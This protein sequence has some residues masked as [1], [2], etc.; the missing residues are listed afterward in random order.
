M[1]LV[2]LEKAG[3]IQY[4]VTQNIDG[5]HLRSGFPRRKMAE[6]HGN[7]YLD[8][9]SVCKR[10]FVR[11][12]AVSTVGQK[13]LGVGCPG[14]RDTGRQCRGRLHD[15][16]LDWEHDL[17]H[18]D[19][20]L[21]EKHSIGSD[22]S[23]CLGT[24]LQIIPSGVLPTLAKQSDG[25][26][27]IC[28]LQPTKHDK[29][30]DIIV[31]GYVDDVMQE[32]LSLL[33]IPCAEYSMEQDP[34]LITRALKSKLTK[35]AESE[36]IEW[37]IPDTWFDDKDLIEKVRRKK[38]IINMKNTG[39][40]CARTPKVDRKKR[41][42]PIKA[43]VKEKTEESSS[44]DETLSARNQRYRKRS[45][46]T[47][48]V[49]P[50]K[51]KRRSRSKVNV[52]EDDSQISEKLD[53]KTEHVETDTKSNY[54][55]PEINE[56]SPSLKSVSNLDVV[57]CHGSHVG[58]KRRLDVEEES[59]VQEEGTNPL[60]KIDSKSL[61]HNNGEVSSPGAEVIDG[62]LGN[63]TVASSSPLR[64]VSTKENCVKRQKVEHCE[65]RDSA[66]TNAED[67][68]LNA[69]TI[70][71][72]CKQIM[73]IPI[74]AEGSS[75]TENI[76]LNPVRSNDLQ[77]INP[78]KIEIAPDS[79]LT[80]AEALVMSAKMEVVGKPTEMIAL[81]DQPKNDG[82]EKPK[83]DE[84]ISEVTKT[85]A[86]DESLKTEITTK[87]TKSETVDSEKSALSSKMTKTE[88]VGNSKKTG[89]ITKVAE[90]DAGSKSAKS[91]IASE[92]TNEGA[93]VYSAKTGVTNERTK[94][95]T[96]GEPAKT[97]AV[98]E[99]AETE[100]LS[101]MRK[102]EA[103]TGEPAK[104]GDINDIANTDAGPVSLKAEVTS[105]VTNTLHKIS[106]PDAV[107]ESLKT[108]AVSATPKT[109]AVSATPRTDAVSATPKTDAVSGTPK[110]DAA[111]GTPIR[112][113][114][115][116]ELQRL[117]QLVVLPRLMQLVELLKLKLLTFANLMKLVVFLKQMKTSKQSKLMEI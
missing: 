41:R 51:R 65:L 25:K 55:S 27:V 85:E 74:H 15:N 111:S 104:I 75:T 11:S 79:K 105:K 97:K 87:V 102:T 83:I 22:L 66:T 59:A 44:Q 86:V 7:M 47:D 40:K 13:S 69:N 48:F 71:P 101:R 52:D 80:E 23:V 10:E 39:K 45:S 53:T 38:A 114:Q 17:P 88:T 68:M 78:Q 24:T 93:V 46:V 1:A 3:L 42:S 109:D 70:S 26:L 19:Y 113:M 84:A 54:A 112:L 92:E 96:F 57:A 50:P 6:L 103:T 94:A 37:T 81:C 107:Y 28:N 77:T 2:A 30:A 14:K 12:T 76:V 5:L 43:E 36:L 110:T 61:T 35:V 67:R 31:N 64:S 72:D 4:L 117:M 82:V 73:K 9:C 60:S 34:V 99:S 98:G 56:N 115:L 91:E 16:I 89:V 108:D 20:N 32:L 58:G 29:I 21:A 8:K 62:H 63:G 116:V 90:N 49:M 33:N 106:K 100:V 95:E 18:L